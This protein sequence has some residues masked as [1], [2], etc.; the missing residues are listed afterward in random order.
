MNHL[1]TPLAILMLAFAAIPVCAQPTAS[2]PAFAATTLSLDASGE[3]RTSPDMATI[4]I[5]VDTVAPSAGQ[6]MNANAS[7]MSKVI[8]T[9]KSAGLEPRDLQTSNLSLSPQTVDQEGQAPRVT[10]YRATDE[11]SVTVRDLGRIGPIADAV[12][13]AGATNI[14]QISFGLADPLAAENAARLAAVKALQDKATLYAQATGYRIAR[15]VNLT[16]GSAETP[17]PFQPRPMMAMRAMAPTPVETGDVSVRVE[18]SGLFE[19][20]R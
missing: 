20:S 10:G 15:L 4:T 17:T 7:R 18:V 19:L 1:P 6:A 3:V 12:V 2:D 14:G 8:A 13:G 9:L 5:G 16:E 11:L